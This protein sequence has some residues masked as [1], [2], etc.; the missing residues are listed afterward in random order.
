MKEGQGVAPHKAIP[1]TL[2]LK[3][4]AIMKKIPILVTNTWC[5]KISADMYRNSRIY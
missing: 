4:N 3:M 1:L 5:S 2:L